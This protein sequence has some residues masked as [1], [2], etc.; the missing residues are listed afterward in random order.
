M[1]ASHRIDPEQGVVLSRLWGTLTTVE[2]EEHRRSIRGD[3]SFAPHLRYIVDMRGVTVLDYSCARVRHVAAT[4]HFRGGQRRAIVAANDESYGMAR[5]FA[6]FA[7]FEGEVVEVFR[8]WADA[9]AWL[10]VSGELAQDPGLAV[11]VD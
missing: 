11:A 10:G 2:I 7:A 6:T 5:M 9:V 8:E 4:Q 3:P 1:P